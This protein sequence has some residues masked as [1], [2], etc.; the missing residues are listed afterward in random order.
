MDNIIDCEVDILLQMVNKTDDKFSKQLWQNV[1]KIAKKGRR[2]GLG[3]TALGDCIASMNMNFKDSGD[4]IEAAMRVKMAAEL[5]ASIDLGIIKGPFHDFDI[6]K[7]FIMTGIDIKGANKFYEFLLE[8]YPD[9]VNRMIKYNAR[10]NVSTST[11]APSGSLSILASKIGTTSGIE[12]LFKALYIRR[13]KVNPSEQYDFKDPNTGEVFQ[14]YFVAHGGLK[15]FCKIALNKDFDSLSKEDQYACFKMSP[16]YMNQA[17]D[18]DWQDRLKIQSIIQKY[19][20]SAISTTIN[21]PETISKDVVKNIYINA[22]ESG[23]KGTTVYVE[24]SRSGILVSEKGQSKEAMIKHNAPK[25]PNSLPC[26]IHALNHNKQK[27]ICAVGLMDNTPY[28]IFVFKNP[29]IEIENQSGFIKKIKSG[30]YQL[31]SIDNSIIIIHHN[32]HVIPNFSSFT[33]RQ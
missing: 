23:L 10:R 31:L 25:R 3:F 15:E 16:Y 11:V 8:E 20:S 9:A 30:H 1:Y 26:N 19:T 5:D 12:P 6:S 7:E 14:E 24:N 2:I 32:H 13:R 28:E 33:F 22:Y 27:F 18:I 17:E 29:G 4:F 21:L